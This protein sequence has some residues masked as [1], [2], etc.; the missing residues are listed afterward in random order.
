MDLLTKH[1]MSGLEKVNVVSAS[2]RYDNP[3]IDL[4]EKAKCLG[5]SYPRDGQYER[6]G[7]REQ[8][9]T[10]NR[11]GYKKRICSPRCERNK[12]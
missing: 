9:N 11:D 8:G 3:D 12:E 5:R 10:Q 1:I 6:S 7:K 2:Q 4:N